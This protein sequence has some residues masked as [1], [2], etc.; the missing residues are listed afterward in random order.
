VVVPAPAVD[1]VQEIRGRLVAVLADDLG[2]AGAL[3]T[4]VAGEHLRGARIGQRERAPADV[5]G[6]VVVLRTAA[7]HEP[8]G[9]RARDVRRRLGWRRAGAPAFPVRVGLPRVRSGVPATHG[10][11]SAFEESVQ[12]RI[13]VLSA[14][15]PCP[16]ITSSGVVPA[17]TIDL[18]IVIVTTS[19][20]S[21]ST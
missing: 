15:L 12:P 11:G 19:G 2:D 4:A 20:V 17:G 6:D 1:R 9:A 18:S 3:L 8:V 16:T 7:G 10:S 5:D 21:G 13:T 14:A